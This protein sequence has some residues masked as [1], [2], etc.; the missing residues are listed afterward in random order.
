MPPPA[1]HHTE[2]LSLL[3][4]SGPFLSLPVLLDVFPQ[5]L[6]AHDSDLAH[7][8]RAA[9]E[10]WADNQGG[11]RP[12]P[13]IHTAW[14]QYVLTEVLD[15]ADESLLKGQSIPAGL[16]AEIPE[17]GIRL[18]PDLTL[19]SPK[20]VR[21]L[22]KVYPPSQELD[23]HP[24]G[25]HW[26]AS[27]ATQMME[28]L[29]ATEVKLGLVTNGEQWMLVHAPQGETTGFISWYAHLWFDEPLTLRAFI[30][31]LGTRRF[32]GVPTEETLEAMLE[33][34]TQDQHE[35]TDQLGYQVRQAVV[36]EADRDRSRALLADVSEERLYEAA[37]TVMMRL[38]FLLSA[39]ER[40]LLPLDDPFYAEYYAVSTLRAQLREAADQ[41]GED[42][43]ERR[44]DAWNHLL[45]T[46]RAVYAGVGHDRLK[47][48]AYG[49]SLFDPDR[50]PFIE[51]AQRGQPARDLWRYNDAG[52]DGS[53][54]ESLLGEF[55]AKEEERGPGDVRT[56]RIWIEKPI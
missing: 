54:H 49:G 48:I 52:R 24:T 56:T 9:H 16:E 43:L 13:A 29:H 35:V 6:E 45:A 50:F 28:L 46:F 4:I 27:V 31:L 7:S 1:R 2:W 21:L 5:G 8:L 11:V 18:R 12:D 19:T 36:D 3:E 40:K 41:L 34:S 20:G 44:T 25:S 14:I 51:A 42:V 38:V 30:S 33:R 53:G 17:H 23:K 10:E 39:E 47:M 26:K 15:F 22:L 37:L 55:I 32:F